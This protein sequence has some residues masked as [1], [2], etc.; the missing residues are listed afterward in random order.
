MFL[1]FGVLDRKSM[2]VGGRY[3]S[4]SI[5]ILFFAS[6]STC[7]P[8]TYQ[9]GRNQEKCFFED[10]LDDEVISCIADGESAFK[11]HVTDS[12]GNTLWQ[13]NDGRDA[14][15]GFRTE[16]MGVV[17][18]CFTETSGSTPLINFE[19]FS[20]AQSIDYEDIAK[21][22][23][24][25]PLQLLLREV[26]DTLRDVNSQYKHLIRRGDRHE[27]TA[28]STHNLL[29]WTGFI[30]IGIVI[31]LGL[32]QILYLRMFFKKKNVL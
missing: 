9:L 27:M 5:L 26:T 29:G 15:F 6:L 30:T 12:D 21:K 23:H 14:S 4:L 8:V 10:A 32:F 16:K 7:T 2:R 28:D 24:L 11:I 17:S 3:I 13:T 22:E 1:G 25:E 19:V 20:G 31:L 18:L